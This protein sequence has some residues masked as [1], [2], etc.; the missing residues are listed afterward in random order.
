MEGNNCWAE[1]VEGKAGH[2]WGLPGWLVRHYPTCPD[3]VAVHTRPLLWGKGRV[4]VSLLV[5]QAREVEWWGRRSACLSNDKTL[6]PLWGRQEHICHNSWQ[7][8]AP[9]LCCP[10]AAIQHHQA[11]GKSFNQQK[12]NCELTPCPCCD[13]HPDVEGWWE[14][15]GLR[16][17]TTGKAESSALPGPASMGTGG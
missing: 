7:H 5:R 3:P 2:C 15:E 10:K 16:S 12:E 6:V 8:C 13:P 4:G 9:S 11:G 1:D 17:C 14:R